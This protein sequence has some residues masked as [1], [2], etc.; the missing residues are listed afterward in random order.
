M[1]EPRNGATDEVCIAFRDV[2]K[3]F[4]ELEVLKGITA[5]IPKGATVAVLG[6]SGSGKS[7]LVRCVNH[8]ESIT[9]GAIQVA[10]VTMT[11][12]G[13]HRDARRLSERKI[14][15]YRTDIG[16]VFQSFNLFQHLTV[17][18]NLIEAPIGVL[19]WSRAE[20]TDRAMDLLQKV[21]LSE[22][23]YVYPSNL[24]GGQQQRVAIAR[25]LMMQPS[26]MLFDEPTSALDPELTEEVLN[27][28]R[29]LALGGRTSLIVTHELT[30]AKEVASHVM[31][32]DHGLLTE[33]GPAADVFSNP[34][35]DRTRRFFQSAGL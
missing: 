33:F 15:R 16:M 24:S 11:P 29:D 25:A 3:S 6:S 4:G 20:A 10:D 9:G 17:L 32:L 14:A 35:S 31:V 18:R 28:V 12:S 22:K 19:G 8:L 2:R 7:T 30:F 21:G 34:R 1:I 13:P 26:I 27:V 23:A 5:S